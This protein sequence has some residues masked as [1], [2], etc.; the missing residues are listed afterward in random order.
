MRGAGGN[1]L[2]RGI[3]ARGEAGPNLDGIL[4]AA[5]EAGWR[6]CWWAMSE[7]FGNYGPEFQGRLRRECIPNLA[8]DYAAVLHVDSFLGALTRCMRGD[9]ATALNRYMQ[10][11]GIHPTLRAVALIVEAAGPRS[12]AIIARVPRS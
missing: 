7:P 11:D 2:V 6:C 5:A 10:A 4:S 3:T 8:A 1:D 9:P 12:S